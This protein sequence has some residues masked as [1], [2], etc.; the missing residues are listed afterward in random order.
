MIFTPSKIHDY[1]FPYFLH[2]KEVYY[3]DFNLI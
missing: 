2:S 1:F 3:A